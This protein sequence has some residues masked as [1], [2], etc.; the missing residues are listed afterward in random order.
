MQT[1]SISVDVL[2]LSPT[3]RR[4]TTTAATT[5]PTSTTS[6]R[7]TPADLLG[8]TTPLTT[9]ATTSTDQGTSSDAIL[10]SS[11]IIGASAED[12][13]PESTHETTMAP[14][15]VPPASPTL[16]PP[17]VAPVSRS[18]SNELRAAPESVD[19]S[20]EDEDLVLSA[21]NPGAT[22]ESPTV[23]FSLGTTSSE[24]MMATEAPSS[25]EEPVRVKLIDGSS[26]LLLPRTDSHEELNDDGE[27]EAEEEAERKDD[28]IKM[29]L[30]GSGMPSA[31]VEVFE[32]TTSSIGFPSSMETTASIEEI[33]AEAEEN[34]D[35]ALTESPSTTPTL[36]L[37]SEEAEE[38]E[39]VFEGTK[40]GTFKIGNSLKSG[41]LDFRTRT[42]T[43]T[44]R[45]TEQML[46]ILGIRHITGNKAYLFVKD[47]S[48]LSSSVAVKVMAE[49]PSSVS[50]KE[51]TLLGS[52]RKASDPTPKIATQ[53]K[54]VVKEYEFSIPE[55]APSGSTVGQIEDGESKR[56]VRTS[57]TAMMFV[58]FT[59]C[60][61][62][63]LG[64]DL[65]LSCPNEDSCLD[66]EKQK[67]HHV[68]LVDAQGKKSPPVY[69]KVKLQDVNDN[70]PRLEAS[71]NF[72]RLS[73]N[74]L[75]MPFIVQVLDPDEPASNKNHLT[76]SGDA[77]SF[78]GVKEISTNLYQIDVIGFAPT[79]HHQLTFTVS[80]GESSSD[81]TVEVQV[82]NSR[83]H[84]HFRRPK[85]LRSITADKVHQGNQL[86]QVELEGVPIDEARFVILQG[87]PGWLS[88][89]DYGGRV[90]VAKFISPVES[91]TYLVEIGAVDRQSN[92]LLAQTQLEIKVR[93]QTEFSVPFKMK[94]SGTV[95][96]ASVFAI[97]ENGQQS[98]FKMA[99][100]F[101]LICSLGIEFTEEFSRAT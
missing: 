7:T 78:L 93:R 51:L 5:T 31:S 36:Q 61:F 95:R 70:Q 34:N 94:K 50:I 98:D 20:V 13:A 80:D 38:L 76:L 8:T 88:I 42:P 100:C 53:S 97:D 72:I 10:D 40:N 55:D 4:S 66:Y 69:V 84:A 74:K 92:A 58:F 101:K 60:R 21:L 81:L 91:G 59:C 9:T 90:G 17:P 83:S 45:W 46:S 37:P 27:E 99:C 82:Q 29:S 41:D 68:L 62:S 49:R 28:K 67:V 64:S 52:P 6:E 63:L 71:D 48:L 56:V 15:A 30:E 3:T 87:N 39:L 16:A 75:I 12:N 33:L 22:G 85:Y 47:P 32:T 18:V 14:I 54:S 23:L 19:D 79:G 2:S 57:G 1:A 73:N 89:D 65:I 44:C 24:Q 77:A 11:A 96:V 86:L 35:T 43:Q 25:K 26:E